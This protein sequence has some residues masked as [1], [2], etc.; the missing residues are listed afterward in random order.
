MGICNDFSYYI[1]MYYIFE[2]KKVFHNKKEMRVVL[3]HLTVEA[4]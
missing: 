3:D 4:N 1:H 2:G